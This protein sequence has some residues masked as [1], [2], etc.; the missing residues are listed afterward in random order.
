MNDSNFILEMRNISKAFP[1]VQALDDVPFECRPGEVH[2]LVGENGAGKS[3]LMKI[4][5]GAYQP[6]AGTIL[7][8]GQQVEIN[9][10]RQGQQLGISI[11]YQEFNLEPY[12]DVAENIFLGREPLTRL[13]LVDYRTMYAEASE[14]MSRIE[15]ALDLREWVSALGVAEQQMVEI[16]K[17][18][19]FKSKVVIMDEPTSALSGE[20][21]ERL[22]GIIRALKSQGITVIYISHRIREIFEVADRVTVLKDGKVVGTQDI[23]GLDENTLVRMMIGRNLEAMFPEKGEGGHE[24]IMSVRGLTRSGVFEDIT[25]DLRKG[26]VLGLAGLV[27]ARR[28]E[29]ARAIFGADPVDRGEISVDGRPVRIRAPKDAVGCGI[30][31]V[32]EDRRSDG[33]VL[34]LPVRSNVV[35][36][37]LERIKRFIFCQKGKEREITKKLIDSLAIKTPSCEHEVECLSGGNQQKV[38]LSKWLAAV[39]QVIIFDEPTR[40][41]DVGAKAEIHRLMRELADGGT[42]ILMISSE[43]PEILGMSDRVLVM[44]EGRIAA[45][46]SADEATEERVMAAAT[47]VWRSENN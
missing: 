45:T 21:S 17:A 5:T 35:L 28:T 38:V 34:C 12:L 8:D 41:I 19:S 1:G 24:P 36:P 6:D 40:G 30:G 46:L 16:A 4:L 7:L 23:G 15:M 44:H 14:L 25:F 37:A 22:F 3:T 27:G 26:E 33:L 29:V 18:L 43:L 20:E 31:L 42:G 9:D 11:I 2:A 10:P 39:P 32:P 13:G 47:G